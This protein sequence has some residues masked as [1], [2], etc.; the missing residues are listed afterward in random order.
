M[1]GDAPADATTDADACTACINAGGA[2]SGTICTIASSDTAKV[3]CPAGMECHV[4][5]MGADD[6]CKDGV[7]CSLATKCQINCNGKQACR[8]GD[9]VCN[10]SMDSCT[11]NCI[12]DDAC[13][14]HG[15]TCGGG[16]CQGNCIGANACQSG[17]VICGP[18]T[19]AAD[20]VG[21]FACQNG[22]CPT[23][24][25]ACTRNCCGTSSCATNT[26]A[27]CQITHAGCP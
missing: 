6:A 24:P 5:C 23:E 18:G 19:C 7:D 13:Q 20:C 26:C 21:D 12:G 8:D 9:V 15:I 11:V 4:F 27:T 3:V 22:D 16:P 25:A 10:T 2:C 1:H 14:N 17:G